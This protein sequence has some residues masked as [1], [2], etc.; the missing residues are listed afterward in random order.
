[1]SAMSVT[2]K[3]FQVPICNSFKAKIFNDQ[4]CYEVDLDKFSNKDNIENELKTGLILLMDF[5]EDR[6]VTY[7]KEHK[8]EVKKNYASKMTESDDN[9]Q[10]YI[11]L[12]TVGKHWLIDSQ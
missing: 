6:Q 1:M 4:L 5:N 12:D 7:N 8:E 10:V 2:V 3:E 11:Y 9:E